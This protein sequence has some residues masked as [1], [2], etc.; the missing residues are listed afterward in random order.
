MSQM[1]YNTEELKNER[2]GRL[3]ASYSIPAI[4]AMAVTSLYNVI[5]SIFIGH[6]IGPLALSALA[7]CFPLMNLMAAV[8]LLVAVGGATVCS[9]ALGRNNQDEAEAVLG[10]VLVLEVALGVIFAALFQ[11][12]LD[13]SL[14]LFGASAET[15]PLARRYMRVIILGMPVSYAMLGLNYVMRASGSVSYTHLTLPTT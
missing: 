4:V 9:I 14:T 2:L 13:P 8:C 1:S 5:D 11:V 3:L 10:H 12:F 15:L 7:V 6:G